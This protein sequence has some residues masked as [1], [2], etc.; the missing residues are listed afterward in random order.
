MSLQACSGTNIGFPIRLN[1]NIFDKWT[2][3][4]NANIDSL[5]APIEFSV[6]WAP[7]RVSDNMRV[8]T[9]GTVFNINF[10]TIAE[11]TTLTVGNGV[12]YVCESNLS[13]VQIQ[14]GTL[15]QNKTATQEVI[16]SF[17]I[18]E[19]DLNPSSPH[20]ILFCRPVVLYEET[21]DNRDDRTFWSKVNSVAK[22]PASNKTMTSYDIQ[23]IYAYN[24]DILMPMITYDT[25]ITT[26]LSSG[27]S[28]LNGSLQVRVHVVTQPLYIPS[29]SDGTGKCARVTSYLFTPNIRNIFNQSRYNQ[30]RYN[31]IKFNTGLN[32][33]PPGNTNNLK[34]LAPSSQISTWNEVQQ[35]FEYL[36][37]DIFLGKSAS[38]IAK[39]ESLP[40]N[41][42]RKNQYKCYTI[43]PEKDIKNGQILVDP[44]TG[45]SL[46]SARNRNLL[47]SAGGDA[48]LAFALSGDSG[49]ND[50]IKPGDIELWLT[51][52]ISIIGGGF[53]IVY[54]YHI[55]NLFKDPG[56]A[57]AVVA[58]GAAAVPAAVAAPVAANALV[59]AVPGAA[60]AAGAAAA[61]VP[62]AHI[63]P[64]QRAAHFFSSRSD[65]FKHLGYFIIVFLV[66]FTLTWTLTSKTRK[67]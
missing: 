27:D 16:M 14:H 52:I 58:A 48:G 30:S 49:Q 53:L 5:I 43:D 56:A 34:A 64:I 11:G 7:E 9:E 39:M 19:K 47:E 60:G 55:F 4:A 46:D 18:K 59:V 67:K 62:A 32:T 37:P 54:I 57:A 10:P 29:V 35:K 3:T 1:Q 45:E 31:I 65:A 26:Q 50:G 20:V 21:A 66:I 41:K 13:L 12:K 63:N 23:S 25:C 42:P 61:G 44:T 38:D 17:T 36:V 33:F 2:G 8:S 28:S 40:K 51:I 24:S 6:A 22:T 15:C